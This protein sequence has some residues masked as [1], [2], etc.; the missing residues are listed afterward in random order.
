MR[1]ANEP[2]VDAYDRVTRKL[3]YPA[4]RNLRNLVEAAFS[5]EEAAVFLELPASPE[6]IVAKRDSN[7]SS[8]IA[9]L[10]RMAAA[11]IV[12]RIRKPDGQVT[13]RPEY[14]IEPLC[15]LMMYSLAPY[16]NEET[17]TIGGEEKNRRIADL[18]NR[19]FEEEWYR[20]ARTDEL[21]HRRVE[22]L[23]GALAGMTFTV[24]PAWK[25]LEKCN[26]EA[27]PDPNF[28]LRHV[29]QQVKA[30]GKKIAA[31]P[32]SCKVRARKS[33]APIWTCGSFHEDFMPRHWVDHPRQIYKLW[34]PDE[35]LEMMG[36]CEEEFGLVHVG[37]PPHLYDV[38]TCD[39]EC[40][41]IFTPLKRHAH[42]YEGVEKSPYRSVIDEKVCE[43]CPDCIAR[44]RFEATMIKKDP[45][46]GKHVASINLERCVG[47]GQ[48]VLGCKIDGAIKLELASNIE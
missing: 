46:S 29:V 23:G 41:N 2:D 37:L 16:W 48:C 47:C 17:Q 3:G 39:T 7:T 4:S 1:S 40:C 13:Y 10:D 22:M 20:F 9:H 25:A 38:C 11:G 34:D 32:C 14:M 26:A 42:C 12:R 45:A 5:E 19:F 30:S 31:A 43:G 27:P 24:T 44:C 28:D 35:W 8:V 18:W 15:D 36:R 6:E 33:A 21:I